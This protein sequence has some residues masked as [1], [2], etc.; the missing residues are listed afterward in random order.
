MSTQMVSEAFSPPSNL[1][2]IPENSLFD[3]PDADIILRSCDHREFRVLKLDIIRAST[4]LRKT[5]QDALSSH[6]ASTT[7]SLPSVQLSDSGDTLSSLLSFILPMSSVLPSTIEQTML[8]LSAAQKYQMGF[9][10]SSIRAVIAS[11]DPP[12][13]RRETALQV[14]SLAQTHGL[15]QEAH[16]AA[17]ATL[18]LSFTLDDLEDKLDSTPLVDLHRLWRYHQSVRTYLAD[19]LTAFKTTGVPSEMT[20][21]PCRY[22]TLTWLGEY[23]ESIAK[24]PGLFDIT[25][26]HMF[27]TRHTRT[28][29]CGCMNIPGSAIRAFWMA[30][31]NVVHN[32]MA[33]V[34]ISVYEIYDVSNS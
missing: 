2:Q 8:L 33:R 9:I 12:F 24:S 13:I 3:D 28:P 22:G 21:Q 23:F 18:P 10:M 26:F 7:P 5:I 34:S 16:H 29:G 11:Q 17:R 27:L 30:L 20:S 19:D 31:T 4:V 1:G 15:R 6:T 32:C 14:Y 25:E